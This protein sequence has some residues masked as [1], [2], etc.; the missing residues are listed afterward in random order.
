MATR[1]YFHLTSGE[2]SI[3]DEEGIE[4][5]SIQVAVASVMAAVEEIRALDPSIFDQWWGWQL[6]VADASR[7]TVQV[8]HLASLFAEH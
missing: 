7:Q 6:A 2:T 5:A 4:A 8:I 1:Y 3:Q